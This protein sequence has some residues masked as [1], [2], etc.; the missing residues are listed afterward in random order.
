M[1]ETR[2]VSYRP[3]CVMQLRLRFDR[4]LRVTT[5][6]QEL[7][8]ALDK[9]LPDDGANQSDDGADADEDDRNYSE[10][11]DVDV[12]RY[13][14]AY[15]AAEANLSVNAYRAAKAPDS[16]N[17]VV[18]SDSFEVGLFDNQN[19][20]N[21][22]S[23][24]H[25]VVPQDCV[26]ELPGHRQIGTFHATLAYQDL[27]I[28][29]R[30]LRGAGVTIHFGSV[31]P[32]EFS[33]GMLQPADTRLNERA[34][35]L[36]G[37][38]HGSSPAMVGYVDEWTVTYGNSSTT[39]DIRGRDIRG[40]LADSPVRLSVLRR[41]LDLSKDIGEVVKAILRIHPA[42]AQIGLAGNVVVQGAEWWDDGKIPSPGDREGLTRVRMPA[43]RKKGTN[44]TK[45][46]RTRSRP[47][48]PA[49][50]MTYW[51]IITQ[52]CF[53]V[54][55]IPTFVGNKLHIKQASNLFKQAVRA[56]SG[57]WETP[58]AGGK[59]RTTIIGDV[60]VRTL[61]YGHNI[62]ELK[63]ERKFNGRKL[64][65]VEAVSIDDRS[66]KRGKGKLLRERWPP[67]GI[68]IPTWVSPSAPVTTTKVMRVAIP[69]VTDRKR[70]QILARAYFEET[71]RGE[72]S[73]SVLTK[74]L[75]S[76][77]TDGKDLDMLGIRPGNAL[78]VGVATSRLQGH[79]PLVAELIEH[80]SK[81]FWTEVAA[82]RAVVG[83]K[84]LAEVIVA[85]ERARLKDLT[86]FFYVK[87]VR[88][89]FRMGTGLQIS[90]DFTNYV[91]EM[92]KRAERLSEGT[93]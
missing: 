71:M 46:T 93:L 67:K 64:Q 55:A 85:T 22:V 75:G 1:A 11:S 66:S 7:D 56:G 2:P 52:Y 51:D 34:S 39:I 21:K 33:E 49:P 40:L 42:T 47:P 65:V 72:I 44:A 78:Y 69:G 76:L 4:A 26:V 63:I 14:D 48:T 86:P 59:A 31:T 68:K 8:A 89:E 83:D 30:T 54:G 5:T 25:N 50:T 73:G 70:L 58:F 23:K 9:F 27:P 29:P 57:K 3:T 28:D 19:S 60:K 38:K 80:R 12:Q 35:I 87:N 84:E 61:L 77:G 53:L 20:D 10:G 41:K 15:A 45:S 92:I 81:N 32:D 43:R 18:R 88:F 62:S 90:L 36:R 17:P 13:I 16:P 24:L 82:V 37:I 91:D 6:Q 79:N 74:D